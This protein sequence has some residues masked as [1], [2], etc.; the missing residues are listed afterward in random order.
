MYY[1]HDICKLK[2]SNGKYIPIAIIDD[3]GIFANKKKV[4]LLKS[5]PPELQDIIDST[6]NSFIVSDNEL[7][8]L[9]S[10]ELLEL[11]TIELLPNNFLNPSCP[12]Y[13]DKLSILNEALV[14]LRYSK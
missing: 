14:V 11:L 2:M 13:D 1:K 8:P 3:F 4:I 6:D 12:L 10:D 7:L 9:T 5:K